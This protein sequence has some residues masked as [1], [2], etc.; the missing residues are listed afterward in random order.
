MYAVAA[1]SKPGIY[2]DVAT[3]S[4][5]VSGSLCREVAWFEDASAAARY[6]MRERDANPNN[7]I[8]LYTDGSCVGNAS[9][10]RAG[11]GVFHMYFPACPRHELGP[12]RC[13]GTPTNNL[14]ELLAIR[15]AI[16]S[17]E[18]H[19][20]PGLPAVIYTDSDYAVQCLTRYIHRWRENGFRTHKG[21][22]V[23]NKGI[24]VD[25]YTRL[26]RCPHVRLKHIRGHINNLGNEAA[27]ALAKS[28]TGLTS[29]AF[30][31]HVS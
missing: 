19:G 15:Q 12:V 21:Q 25:I 30:V 28:A 13:Q 17:V 16:V 5:A 24:L 10:R 6:M 18:T 2:R 9:N 26:Q 4:A 11:Y 7:L 23:K 27:D 14:A 20:D 22:P 29:S 8:E 3:A 1:G 31:D